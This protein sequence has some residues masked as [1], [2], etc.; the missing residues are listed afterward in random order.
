MY[1][2]L[3]DALGGGGGNHH[4]AS[5]SSRPEGKAIVSFK[6]GKMDLTLQT[7]GKYWAT[8]DTRRGQV[9]LKYNDDNCL[10]WEWYDR[11]E[12]AVVESITIPKATKLERATIQNVA[13]SSS[14]SSSST[15]RL[16]YWKLDTEWKMIWLQNKEEE[17]GLIDQVNEILKVPKKPNPALDDDSSPSTVRSPGNVSTSSVSTTTRQVDALSNILEN[18]GMPQ[19][20]MHNPSSSSN[21]PSSRSTTTS[22]PPVGGTLTLA[23]LQGVMAG[24]QEQSFGTSGPG[25]QNIVTPAA[26]T[27]LLHNEQ[28]MDR[29]LQ[30][31]PED[32]RTVEHLEENLRS[33]QVQQTLRGLTAALLPDE[34]GSLN[35]YH[36][37]LANFQ[38]DAA[39]GQEALNTTNNPIQAFLECV[40]AS[41]QKE[42]QEEE[43]ADNAE[44]TNDDEMKD[45]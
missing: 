35:G 24:L 28:V 22:T 30:E 37:I 12:K 16:Y 6:A 3:F 34:T 27:E 18:L 1:S 8:P 45:D 13:G 15:D 4:G 33:P 17:I 21:D 11:R 42:E 25:L 41:V 5:S 2:D 23:D 39:T 32:Q 14:S 43:E 10:V 20:E 38:L 40:L 36:S 19:G 7:S 31:L 26:I 44:S 29:L 9:N